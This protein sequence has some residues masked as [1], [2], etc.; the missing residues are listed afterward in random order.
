MLTKYLLWIFLLLH[1]CTALMAQH[2]GNVNYQNAIRYTDTNI[3][4]VFS[5]SDELLV[6]VKGLANVK[7]DGYV[8]VFSLTQVGKTT[9]EVTQLI[10]QRIEQVTSSLKN[11]TD[12]T[13]YVDLVSFVPKYEYEMEKKAFSK[14]TY[15]EIPTGFE[16]KKNLHIQYKNPDLLNELMPILANAE[17]YDLV[18]VDYFSNNLETI[19][20]D[21][22]QKAKTILQE[23]M[24]N[25]QSLLNINID[26]TAKRLTDGYRVLYP[27]EMY[28]SYEA[29]NSANLELKKNMNVQN[30]DK[31]VTQYYQPVLDKEF[32]FVVNPIVL[33]PV[34]QVMY[35]IKVRVLQE[36]PSNTPKN[37]YILVT[38]T[39]ELRDLNIAK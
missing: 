1:E 12:V 4:T 24:K 13:V 37:N 36:S 23:K 14:K 19:K 38:P 17:M 34:I 11:R 28:R 9:A 15:N 32:D 18:R 27:T 16:L 2:S 21:L 39:G 6:S 30:V 25:Y 8:A 26:T 7:A 22:M 31:N 35:E 10:D 20:R 3:N 29:Y 33:E 5:G